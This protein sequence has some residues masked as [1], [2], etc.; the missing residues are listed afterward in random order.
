MLEPK[1][2]VQ[3]GLL[4]INMGPQHPATHGVINFMVETDGEVMRRAIPDVGYL[5][6]GIEKLAEMTPWPGF[7]PYTDRTDYLAAMFAN[8]GYVMAVE[9]LMG[10]EVPRRA[11]Y[12]R[13][14]ACELN[15]IASHLVATG[16]MAMDLGAFTP[17]VHWLRERESIN[18]LMELICGARLTYNYMRIGGVCRDLHPEIPERT[19]RWLDH[20]VP[21]IDEFNRLISGNE[22]FVRR[23]ANVAV[24][25]AEMAITWGFSGPNLRASAVDWDLRRDEPYSVYPDFEFEVPL[26]RAF[27][28]A[29]GDSY[30]RFV[31]RILEI[32][33]S[34]RI[35]RQ[36]LDGMPEGEFLGKVPRKI[37]PPQGEAYARVESARGELG[38]YAIS[39]GS[40]KP[41]RVKIRTGS[42]TAC[43][44]IE[45]ISPGLMIADLVALIGSLDVVAPEIDR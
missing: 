40:D 26:G 21:M 22:I 34:V 32:R 45:A 2:E 31:V 15:R 27:A 14:L 44:A 36:A 13:V 29:V 8:Q 6:R 25:P 12:L 9:R 7:I 28:G 18:D 37:K 38:F 20:F 1:T 3:E 19:R 30:D 10:V 42:F 33:Q 5:H 41:L 11:E 4:R 39:D 43:G 16:C 35:I 24:V 17:F 23:L